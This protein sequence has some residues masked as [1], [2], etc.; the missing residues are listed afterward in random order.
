MYTAPRPNLGQPDHKILLHSSSKYPSQTSNKITELST[1]L[2]KRDMVISASEFLDINTLTL[3]NLPKESPE[4][5]LFIWVITLA[6]L[7]C[8][9]N[10][11]KSVDPIVNIYSVFRSVPR[12]GLCHVTTPRHK[13]NL[14]QSKTITSFQEAKVTIISVNYKKDNYFSS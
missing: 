8:V 2:F 5:T 4:D 6:S 11:T 3:H 14:L 9:Q 10:C 7:L 12:R 13:I 1:V